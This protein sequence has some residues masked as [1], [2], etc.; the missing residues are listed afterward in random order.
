MINLNVFTVGIQLLVYKYLDFMTIFQRLSCNHQKSAT[1][2]IS[3]GYFSIMKINNL[4]FL[5]FYPALYL[6]A[7]YL[8]INDCV[9]LT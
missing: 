1:Y 3:D 4:L 5:I 9:F 7:N 8:I 2:Q 6:L